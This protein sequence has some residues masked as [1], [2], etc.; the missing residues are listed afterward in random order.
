MAIDNKSHPGKRGPGCMEHSIHAALLRSEVGFWR[1]MIE[2]SQDTESLESLERM[3][4][5]LALAETRLGQ[6]SNEETGTTP[7]APEKSSNV[8][9]LN[10][11]RR[12]SRKRAR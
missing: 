10:E 5:A 1:D 2:T 3:H 6:L 4:C 7:V 11:A 9:C 8:Y 12:L